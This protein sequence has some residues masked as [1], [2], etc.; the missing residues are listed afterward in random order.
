MNKY[1][2]THTHLYTLTYTNTEYILVR[3]FKYGRMPRIECD[4]ENQFFATMHLSNTVNIDEIST[5]PMFDRCAWAFG[6]NCFALTFSIN[7]KHPK[8]T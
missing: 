2:H 8:L 5:P 6:H 7:D 4:C 3:Y 1:T